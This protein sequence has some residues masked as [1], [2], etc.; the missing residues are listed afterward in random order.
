MPGEHRFDEPEHSL[1][2]P[3][4]WD[5]AVAMGIG[6]DAEADRQA[7]TDLAD[8]MLVGLDGPELERL[9]ERAIG[10]LWSD[11][12]EEAIGEA[13]AELRTSDGWEEA[14]GAAEGEL[15]RDGCRAEVCREVACHLAMQ[16]GQEDLPEPFFCLHCFEEAAARET[17]PRR[18]AVAAEASAIAFR[19]ADCSFAARSAAR[20]RLARLAELGRR[21]LPVLAA[22]W[23]SMIA[24]PTPLEPEADEV[25]HASRARARASS[26]YL[27]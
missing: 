20:T 12:L 14:V 8:A 25:W 16:L 18:R 23:R 26:A 13:L 15:R 6:V 19:D 10:E 24:A 3:T 22:E 4:A 1:F 5:L 9:A 21:A 17:G 7:L 27:N 2:A 11:E